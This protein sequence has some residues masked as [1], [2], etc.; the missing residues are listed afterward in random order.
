M[1]SSHLVLP[2]YLS[3]TCRSRSRAGTRLL[4]LRLIGVTAATAGLFLLSAWAGELLWALL[5][6]VLIITLGEGSREY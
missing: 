1:T 4:A 3:L 5:A 2:K 6:A